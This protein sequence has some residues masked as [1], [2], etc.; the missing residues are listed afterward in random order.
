MAI[1]REGFTIEPDANEVDEVFEVP[2]AHL[3]NS[4]NH[5]IHTREFRGAQRMFYAMPYEERFIWGATAGMLRDL[6]ECLYSSDARK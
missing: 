3:M 1:V 6:Y 4:A 5:E 2:F